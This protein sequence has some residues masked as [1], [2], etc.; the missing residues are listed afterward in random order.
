MACKQRD[1]SQSFLQWRISHGGKPLWNWSLILNLFSVSLIASVCR[2][3]NFQ[4]FLNLTYWN[5]VWLHCWLVYF[6]WKLFFQG[7]RPP[8]IPCVYFLIR[9]EISFLSVREMITFES[10]FHSKGLGNSFMV[11][12]TSTYCLFQIYAEFVWTACILLSKSLK[13]ASSTLLWC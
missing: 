9:E 12:S 4:S 10:Y 11:E 1:L 3:D 13:W 2:K 6:S 5:L 7:C 8:R